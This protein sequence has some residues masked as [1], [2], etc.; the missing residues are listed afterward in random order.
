MTAITWIAGNGNWGTAADWSTGTVPGSSYD[1]TISAPGSYTA[2]DPYAPSGSDRQEYWDRP[3]AFASMSIVGLKSASVANPQI[4]WRGWRRL[5]W[6]RP[7]L[8]IS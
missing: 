8:P 6:R 1:A 3:N 2:H 5:I 7:I 4:V